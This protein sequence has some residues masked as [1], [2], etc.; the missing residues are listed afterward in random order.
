ML[1]SGSMKD[2]D[3]W[4]IYVLDEVLGIKALN[5][6]DRARITDALDVLATVGPG[7]GRPLVD[8]TAGR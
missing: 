4:S 5:R 3:E 7:L 1:Y 6:S 2:G 8:T